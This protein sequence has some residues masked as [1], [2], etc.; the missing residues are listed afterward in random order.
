M[1]RKFKKFLRNLMP[2]D[3]I[4]QA[5]READ[6]RSLITQYFRN[7]PGNLTFK[8][9]NWQGTDTPGIQN[10]EGWSDTLN[11]LDNKQKYGLVGLITN[12][13]RSSTR[14]RGINQ[15]GW[16]LDEFRGMKKEDFTEVPVEGS[17]SKREFELL[18]RLMA[19]PKD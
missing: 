11:K 5:D 8:D 19:S 4:E 10:I 9:L 17:L 6:D 3:L 16:T 1:E 2:K 7:L 18:H 15:P 14:E 12:A 13:L